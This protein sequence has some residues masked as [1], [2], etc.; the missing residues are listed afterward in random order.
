[1]TVTGNADRLLASRS[2]RLGLAIGM[3]LAARA[4]AGRAVLRPVAGRAMLQPA[5]GLV[6][7]DRARQM[8]QRRLSRAPGRLTEQQLR[9]TR[10]A[11]AHHMARV[12]PLLERR[13]GADLPGVVDRHAVASRSEW[14][15]ANM[16]TFKALVAHLEPSLRPR[17]PQ[18]SLRVGV[19]AAANRLLTTGQVGLLLGYLG[20]RVLGQYDVALLSAEQ[21]PGRL[22]FVEENI[23]SAAR[24]LGVPLDT[25][26]L[27]ICLHETT[28]AFEM[29]AHPWLRPYMRERL[30]RQLSLFAEQARHL[31]RQGLRYA[32]IR[33]RAAAAEGSWRGL[34]EPEQRTLFRETQAVMSL[35]EG[36]SDWVMDEVGAE[37]I[38]DVASIRRRFETRRSQRRRGLDRI[39]A[40]IT[41]LDLKLAQY[42]RGERFVAGVHALGGSAAIA[43][44]WDG[45]ETLPSEAELDDPPAWLARVMPRPGGWP[46]DVPAVDT[47][48][49]RA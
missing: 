8:A 29:E 3:G 17:G 13:L 42:Q 33:W 40:R 2:V 37:L 12:V 4:V 26:R 49:E 11:Y 21:A 46:S 14:A 31:Q 15:D 22:L 19:A 34:L 25:F 44:L 16:H 28:H 41:G 10:P 7:W 27:W 6:D 5:E 1:V 47:P 24:T 35:M 43:H 32:A 23:R 18:G 45:P 39:L 36:F 48:A 20:T 30:E 9:A 38:P